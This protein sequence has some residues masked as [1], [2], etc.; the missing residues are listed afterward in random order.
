MQGTHE[1]PQEIGVGGG[2]RA[3]ER[4]PSTL[5][6][7]PASRL[8]KNETWATHSKSGSCSLIFDRGIMGRRP[9]QG[10]EKRLLEAQSL[11]LVIPTGAYPDFLLRAS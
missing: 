2:D 4:V 1:T 7:P 6:L 8:L 11:P 9:T 5:H 3:Q 10:D